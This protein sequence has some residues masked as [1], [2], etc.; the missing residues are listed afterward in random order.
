MTVALY[1]VRHAKARNR[2][3]WNGDDRERPLTKAGVVQAEALATR[4]AQTSPARLVSS[5][6]ARCVQTLEP[7]AELLGLSIEI[8]DLLSEGGA[9]VE[10]LDMLVSV[11][12]RT[13]LCSHG[14][15]IPEVI[16]A[17]ERRG[18]DIKGVPNWRKGSVW[19]IERDEAGR[20]EAFS[21]AEA[22]PPPD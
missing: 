17:L 19:V 11:P 13:V 9:F 6:F 3:D 12:D 20:V 2:R 14:D 16:S 5:P 4:L 1:L 10:V 8:D 21:R 7:L 22:W 18:M 15:V